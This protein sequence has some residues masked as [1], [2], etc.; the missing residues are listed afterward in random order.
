[1]KK[2]DEDYEEPEEEETESFAYADYSGVVTMIQ[3]YYYRMLEIFRQYYL[4]VIKG[5]DHKP[6]RQAIQSYIIILTQLLKRYNSIQNDKTA[7]KVLKDIDEFTKTT[8][9]M[10]FEKLKDCV[11]T[12]SDAH[13]ILGLNKIEFQKRNPAKAMTGC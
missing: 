10:N 7:N 3:T 5:K 1:M 9:T 12:I 2:P 13:N 4:L 8:G 6:Q 11:D